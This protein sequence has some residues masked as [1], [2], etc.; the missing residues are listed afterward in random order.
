MRLDVR[1]RHRN[2]LSCNR[3][4]RIFN[5]VHVDTSRLLTEREKL[6]TFRR[7]RLFT[8]IFQIK[9]IQVCLPAKRKLSCNGAYASIGTHEN[10]KMNVMSLYLYNYKKRTFFSCIKINE[11]LSSTI[12]ERMYKLREHKSKSL[13]VEKWA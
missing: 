2:F 9:K 12:L 11:I 3:S 5:S 8:P 7:N 13:F 10:E 1:S 6:S 4:F